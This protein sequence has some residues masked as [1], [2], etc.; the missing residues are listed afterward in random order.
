MWREE[1]ATR[2]RTGKPSPREGVLGVSLPPPASPL[3]SF[4][5]SRHPLEAVRGS[6]KRTCGPYHKQRLAKYYGLYRDLFHGATFVPTGPP[7]ACGLCHR[8]DHLVPVYYGNE[9]TPAEVTVGL[10]PS[11]T[12]CTD[13]SYCGARDSS[14]LKA[15]RRFLWWSRAQAQRLCGLTWGFSC[16]L[17]LISQ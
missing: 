12:L 2:L 6:G 14:F 7:P 4:L 13:T 10:C 1:R 17:F 8:R 5:S 9:I 3:A 11:T 16:S 15:V